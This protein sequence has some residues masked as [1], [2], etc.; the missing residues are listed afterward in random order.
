MYPLSLYMQTLCLYQYF[1]PGWYTVHVTTDK[2]HLYI[3]IT[4]RPLFTFRFTLGVVYFMV[5]TCIH[6]YDF[7]QNIFMAL[8]TLC[9]LGTL[10][11]S[12]LTPSSPWSFYCLRCYASSRI[13]YGWN[14]AVYNF[15]L[16]FFHFIITPHLSSLLFL[17]LIFI[18]FYLQITFYCLDVP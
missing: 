8:K 18:S 9:V 7:I 15:S 5:W 2:P 11:Y 17:G 13:L 16:G 6:H 14:H 12:S 10:L 1:P 4:Q 3:I